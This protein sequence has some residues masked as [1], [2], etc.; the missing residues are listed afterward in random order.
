[1]HKMISLFAL[2]F[3][4]ALISCDKEED[5]NGSHNAGKNCISCHG[6]FNLAG[7]VYNKNLS[8]PMTGATINV[9]S[10][11]GGT[12]TLL[13]TV[14]SD[15]SGNFYTEKNINFDPGVYISIK[16]TSGTVVNKTPAVTSGAC[17]SCH[18]GS[19][20]KISIE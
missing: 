9:Y 6:E 1:M 16:S 4:F 12:G 2:M 17:N 18:G 3:V 8:S 7:T 20:S 15:N 19:T 10:Q 11:P 13:A 5:T 14:T